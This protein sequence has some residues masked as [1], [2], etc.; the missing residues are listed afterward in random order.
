MGH[1]VLQRLDIM[2]LKRFIFIW[3]SPLRGLKHCQGL[4]FLPSPFL[5]LPLSVSSVVHCLGPK[6]T[7]F[8]CSSPHILTLSLALPPCLAVCLAVCLSSSLPGSLFLLL[9]LFSHSAFSHFF[10]KLS[11][12]ISRFLRSASF[13]LSFCSSPWAH[14]LLR[15][16]EGCRHALVLYILF[17]A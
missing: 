1:D 13:V 12:S 2:I 17:G 3:S 4:F 10:F 6:Q 15:Y 16:P 7:V 8:V 5:F 14:R 9:I 11:L